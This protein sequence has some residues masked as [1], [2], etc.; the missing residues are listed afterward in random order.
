MPGRGTAGCSL[1]GRGTGAVWLTEAGMRAFKLLTGRLGS[2]AEWHWH[3]PQSSP[4]PTPAPVAG[5]VTPGR[6]RPAGGFKFPF[7]TGGLGPG[8]TG[9]ALLCDSKTD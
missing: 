3:D 9:S 4:W 8:L 2:G 5:T 7:K 6:A 1:P